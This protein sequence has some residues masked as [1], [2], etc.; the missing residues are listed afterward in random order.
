MLFIQ[1]C[2]SD[3]D[4]SI[5]IV[6]IFLSEPASHS[7][8]KVL[9]IKKEPNQDIKGIPI[10]FMVPDEKCADF[11][12][13]AVISAIGNYVSENPSHSDWLAYKKTLEENSQTQ[14]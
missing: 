4:F 10:S 8:K 9:I 7:R 2:E 1:L 3:H 6:L 13:Q 11:V 12:K 14:T 5:T